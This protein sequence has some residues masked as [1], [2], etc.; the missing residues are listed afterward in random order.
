MECNASDEVARPTPSSQRSS[1]GASPRYQA[2]SAT[3]NTQMVRPSSWCCSSRALQAEGRQAGGQVG[4]QCT[5]ISG[6]HLIAALY[7]SDRGGRRACDHWG[8]A[9]LPGKAVQEPRCCVGAGCRG[10]P[11]RHSQRHIPVRCCRACCCPCCCRRGSCSLCGLAAP[12]AA[13]GR[14]HRVAVDAVYPLLVPATACS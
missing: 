1:G 14:R 5:A 12:F 11:P 10:Q 7:R 4:R 13:A 8:P 3:Q 2:L 6:L 9:G